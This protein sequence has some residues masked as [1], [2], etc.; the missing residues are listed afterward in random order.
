MPHSSELEG[1]RSWKKTNE[2]LKARA[3][4]LVTEHQKE[5]PSLTSVA[6]QR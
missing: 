1:C 3:M 4:P 2:Q 6:P 5:Y